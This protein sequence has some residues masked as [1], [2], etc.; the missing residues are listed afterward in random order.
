MDNNL[1]REEL[2][3][4]LDKLEICIAKTR[5]KANI[6]ASR[7]HAAGDEWMLALWQGQFLFEADSIL[8]TMQLKLSG[9]EVH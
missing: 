5:D 7:E 9:A 3:L 2:L 1:E 8:A 4:L 6:L